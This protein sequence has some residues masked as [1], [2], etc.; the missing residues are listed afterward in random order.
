MKRK[1]IVVKIGSSLLANRDG[2]IAIDRLEQFSSAIANL[3]K[4]GLELVFITSGAVA[5][6]FQR[7][8]YATRPVTTEKK[9][10]SAAVG[11]GLL[12]E[13]YQ[14]AF[15]QEGIG[16]AQLLLTRESFQQEHQYNNAYATLQELLKRRIIPIIN[17]ND[18]IAVEELTFGDNDWLA[19][20]VA[21]L[22]K[23]DTLILLTD[24]N[25]VYDRA[26]K[27]P[28]AHKMERIENVSSELLSQA[29]SQQS[30]FGTGG[31]R[32][33]LEAARN[34]QSFGIETFIGKGDDLIALKAIIRGEGDGTYIPAATHQ[35]WPKEKQWVGI[36]SPVEG[37]LYIDDGAREALL[38][39][40]NSLLSVGIRDVQGSFDKGAV[41]AVF[42]ESHQ[43]VGKGRAAKSSEEMRHLLNDHK[44]QSAG[45][46]I[47]R[48]H[49]VSTKKG[50][51]PSE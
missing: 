20:L 41:V 44:N 37:E 51:V 2:G 39:G 6:G 24:V 28:N 13:A 9:Q 48:N 32:S 23:A 27:H 26:P 31:M 11:Q 22:I 49:W 45:I 43:P 21:G 40:G 4:E 1:R 33:K 29:G 17:E 38:Y 7:V 18:S 47:H 35:G 19:S 36:Y 46:C 15:M 3:Q 30:T 5:A 12:M 10:A 16:V 34:A 42:D 14:H 8:G 25:G 50:S